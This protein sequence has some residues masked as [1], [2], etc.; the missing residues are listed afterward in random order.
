MGV[1]ENFWILFSKKIAN[2]ATLSELK[3]FEDLILENPEWQYALQNIEDL[4]RHKLPDDPI[5]AEDAFMLH[6]NRIKEKEITV[7]DEQIEMLNIGQNKKRI[8]RWYWAAASV[9]V[10]TGLFGLIRMQMKGD[11]E[12]PLSREV[13]EI[14]TRLGS[15]SR[16]E[17][18]DG[19][20]VWL[21]AGSKLT[22]DK[23][24]GKEIREVAL[25]GEGF[26]DVM[27][28]KEKPFIIHT[29]SIDIKV[30]GTVFNVRAYPEDKRTETSLIRGRIEVTI[31]NRP[32]DKI[33]LL[34][35]E[36]LVIENDEVLERD[37]KVTK[38]I[39]VGP[40]LNTLMSINKLKYSPIDS[41][42]A[43][44]GW[45]NNKLVFRDESFEYLAVRMERWYDVKI[46]I[47][48]KKLQQ[49]RLNGTFET[50][51][52]DEALD[53]LKEMTP[54]RYEHTGNKIAI[55]R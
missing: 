6:L 34:P 31:K 32:N 35:S 48:D 13:N 30:L 9:I 50:E 17:L 36:K 52:I 28:M 20:I 55:Q 7:D 19:S 45:I 1:Q 8:K 22:Y 21:N 14:S 41:S 42:L 27:K 44:T 29:S 4:W 3:E 54:F 33:I 51:T 43:E 5:E 10:L 47:N 16:I 24:F 11:R 40:A 37:K 12:K 25:T 46:E 15:K 2:E 23:N 38:E 18:P 53:E 26:F 39:P 49:K